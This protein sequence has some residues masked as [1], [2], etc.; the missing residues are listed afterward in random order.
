MADVAVGGVQVAV[1]VDVGPEDDDVVVGAAEF[2]V[3]Q[4]GV[5]DE[6]GELGGFGGAVGDGLAVDEP[7]GAD[8]DGLAGDG[9]TGERPGRG[10]DGGAVDEFD[11]CSRR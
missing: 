9:G 6:A 5:D 4:R 11:G 8:G 10:G 1:V 3:G 2:A 7:V